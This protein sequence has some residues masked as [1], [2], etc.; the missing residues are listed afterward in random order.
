MSDVIAKG[1]VSQQLKIY[2][3]VHLHVGF[4]VPNKRDK[5][6]ATFTFRL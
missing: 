6:T 5:W 3:D 1:Q 2:N 4:S